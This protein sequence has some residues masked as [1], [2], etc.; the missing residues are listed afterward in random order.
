MVGGT[1]NSLNDPKRIPLKIVGKKRTG[2]FKESL[3]LGATKKAVGG[4]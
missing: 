2:L 4:G 1:N 3:K